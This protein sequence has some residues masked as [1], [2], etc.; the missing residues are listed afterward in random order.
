MKEVSKFVSNLIQIGIRNEMQRIVK[1]IEKLRVEEKSI[2]EAC[3]HPDVEK[4]AGSNTGNYDPSSDRYWYDCNC[5][6]CL[7]RWT[8]D[9]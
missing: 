8:E 3:Q 1:E 7:K 4:V 5:P 6:D 9:Q 2:Q